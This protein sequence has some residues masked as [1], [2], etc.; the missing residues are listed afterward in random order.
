FTEV[1]AN[2]VVFGAAGA[3][4]GSGVGTATGISMLTS[5]AVG[6][7]TSALTGGTF[8]NGVSGGIIAGV[9]PLSPVAG[10]VG[11][12]FTDITNTIHR[13]NN[14][15]DRILV[16]IRKD[17]VKYGFNAGLSALLPYTFGKA[18]QILD[19]VAPASTSSDDLLLAAID[20]LTAAATKMW[21]TVFDYG[22]PAMSEVVKY[23]FD[24]AYNYFKPLTGSGS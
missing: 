6:G 21:K 23:S 3:L 11:S 17:I 10:A 1:L 9:S 16:S 14:K 8:V 2:A 19:T 7:I 4:V 22:V 15:G 20:G 24:Q 18:S 13:A 12:L 5:G